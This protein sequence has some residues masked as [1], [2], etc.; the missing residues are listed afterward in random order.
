MKKLL[1]MATAL[2]MI[3]VT[4][5]AKLFT[6]HVKQGL[7]LDET[8]GFDSVIDVFDH[9][10][11]GLST[12]FSTYSTTTASQTTLDFRGIMMNLDFDDDPLATLTFKVD[13]LGIKEQFKGG[14][15][16]ASFAL[17]K[18]YLKNNKDGLL[19]RILKASVADT[20]YDM[21]A[22]NPNSLMATMA[23]DTFQR[24]GGGILGNFVS[25]L[26]PDASTHYF[27]FRGDDKKATVYSLPMGK[28]FRFSNGSALMF[29]MPI[30]YTDLDG[31]KSYQAQFGM[32]YMFPVINNE[33]FKWNLTPSARAG[34]VG[35]KDMLSGGLLY[36][37]NLTSNVKV[38]VG[39][40]TYGM[41]N[42]VG[43]IRDFSVK[44]A[45]YEV[46]YDLQNTV[47]KNGLSVDYAINDKW[48]VGSSY[49]YTFYT[50]TELF[51]EDYHDVNFALSRKFREGSYFSG[52]AFVGNYSFDGDDYYAYRIGVNF[53]F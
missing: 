8:R 38:P 6:V 32:G 20:P 9:Y 44:V 53:L 29:D 18:D 47:F 24:G 42:M 41:T 14:S 35:S 11:D 19:K 4:A 40:W 34:A 15:Q 21:V 37:G 26:S 46:E 28:T 39:S 5:D 13:S 30:S 25:Y 31:S 3:A 16:E 23:D 49:N 7:S 52:I 1:L 12:I 48:N 45:G 43:Y 17:F 27:K 50:G 36:S 10:E 22:G 2:S 51:I 33:K